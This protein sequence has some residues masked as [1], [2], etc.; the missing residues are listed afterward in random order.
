MSHPPIVAPMPVDAE[1]FIPGGTRDDS[2]I[3]FVG[4]LSAQKGAEAAIR[5]IA[6]TRESATLDIVGNGPMRDFLVGLASN[7]GVASRI[8]WHAPM[9][10]SR[11]AD[12]SRGCAA[13][14]VPSTGE[15]LGLVAVEAQLCE[16][17]VIAFAS[18][19]LADIIANGETGLLV[20]EGDVAALAAALDDVIAHPELRTRL[21][22][23]GRQTALA[24]FT[25]EAAAT[26][27]ASVYRAVLDRNKMRTHAG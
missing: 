23:A 5:A 19:G 6:A 13:L 4:R 18:G 10:P 8:T 26:Q 25:P 3:L 17:A 11:L 14:V 27:Y 15:G 12:L 2:R 1:I 7:L 9:P 21:G 16:T 20:P 24:R 22:R